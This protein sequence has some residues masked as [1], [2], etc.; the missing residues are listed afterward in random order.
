VVKPVAQSA[1][2]LAK[3]PGDLRRRPDNRTRDTAIL[4]TSR[5]G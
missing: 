3:A 4:K 2:P 1:A 5:Y